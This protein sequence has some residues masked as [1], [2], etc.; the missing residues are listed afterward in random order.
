MREGANSIMDHWNGGAMAPA[1]IVRTPI[2]L[3]KQNFPWS[4]SL[5]SKKYSEGS[6]KIDFANLDASPVPSL[7][8]REAPSGRPQL[9]AKCPELQP[10]R[11]QMGYAPVQSAAESRVLVH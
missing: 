10:Y 4:N 2:M 8:L 5:P 1:I 3:S 6:K 7:W 9:R 11:Y